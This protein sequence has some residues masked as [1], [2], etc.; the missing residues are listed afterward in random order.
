MR[1]FLMFGL[2]LFING[3]SAV[4]VMDYDSIWRCDENRFNWYCDIPPDI[5]QADTAAEKSKPKAASEE[6]EAVAALKKLKEDAERKRAPRVRRGG[7]LLCGSALGGREE[8]GGGS[9]DPPRCGREGVTGSGRRSACRRRR[10][11]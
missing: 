2:C 4:G 11:G 10:R 3:A 8:R 6:D 9:G 5:E 1:I 7:C